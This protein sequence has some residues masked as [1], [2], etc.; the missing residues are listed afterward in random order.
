[1]QVSR[2]II[3]YMPVQFV[4]ELGKKLK[5]HPPT[6]NYKIEYFNYLVHYLTVIQNQQKDN[7]YFSINTKYLMN[8][9][10]WNINQ[11]IKY[12]VNGDL[13]LRDN[14]TVGEKT[15]HYKINP[16]YLGG[17]RQYEVQ[18]G[19]KLFSKLIQNLILRRSHTNRLAP[20]LKRMYE[21]FKEIDF[22]YEKAEEWIQSQPDETKQYYYL[23]SLQMIRDKR[24]RY[25]K[26][27]KT[28]NRL[29]TNLTNLKS[30]LRQFVE[31]DYVSIDLA[32]SQPF[33]L[34]ILL[35][36]IKD[37]IFNTNT[38]DIPL[39][40]GLLGIDIIQWFGKQQYKALAKIHQ[41]EP[42]FKKGE[43]LKFQDSVV[44]GLFYDDLKSSLIDD[45]LSRDDVKDIVFAILFSRNKI[46]KDH[47]R[48]EPYFKEK[49]LFAKVYPTIYKI[50]YL[51]KNKDHTKLSVF[52]QSMESKV[53]IDIICPELVSQDIIPLTIHDSII[54]PR[55]QAKEARQICEKT[56]DNY[57]SMIPKFHIQSLWNENVNEGAAG[58]Q[59][60]FQ[61]KIAYPALIH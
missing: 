58:P 25:F 33:F 5:A 19:T 52:L 45:H 13:L 16:D 20:H 26:R 46:Y 24:F 37:N 44:R 31:G 35:N 50:V 60:G 55:H 43:L 28:N 21:L 2:P 3:F 6:W 36:H 29:D 61:I 40:S 42:F 18:P 51:L 17:F 59:K 53:F 47:R 8:I 54:I 39:C 7:E 48:I 41:N 9:T 11:Y 1:M 38:K 34:N 14:Y 27:N 23:T 4:I 22:D 12:L 56:F 15:Y 32:N 10:V 57:F 30:E 49:R